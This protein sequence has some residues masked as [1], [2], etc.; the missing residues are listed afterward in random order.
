MKVLVRIALLSALACTARA[1]NAPKPAVDTAAQLP[2]STNAP[3]TYFDSATVSAA[4]DKGQ[5]L[6]QTPGYRV[7]ASRR[8]TPGRVE[9]HLYETDVFY[10]VDGTATF[11]T[12]G[13]C[14][15]A[16]LVSPGQLLGTT[17]NG[18]VTHHLKK[19]DVIIIPA[20][21]PHQF[22][23]VSHPFLYFTVKPI[24]TH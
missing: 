15:D 8:E 7:L 5:P 16:K 13:A 4:F 12:G 14:D 20:G 2:A 10:I 23:E 21:L 22:F 6:I 9:I 1:Q 17:I 24:N 18:G 3:A 19:G 11:V